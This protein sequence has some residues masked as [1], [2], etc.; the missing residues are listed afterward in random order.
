[1]LVAMGLAL[2]LITY[3][4]IDLQA[5]NDP[6]IDRLARRQSMFTETLSARRGAIL[7]RHGAILAMSL[8]RTTVF[9][10]PALIAEP[11]P[12]ADK[13]AGLL[14]RP[15]AEVLSALTEADS[16]FVPLARDV[17]PAVVAELRALEQPGIGFQ[18]EPKRFTP[19]QQLAGPV[20]GTVGLDGSGASGLERAFEGKL[21]GKA[22][23]LEA[24]QDPT[25]RVIPAAERRE[26]PAVAG[27]D[28]V[29]TLDQ[30]LQYAAERHLVDSVTKTRAKRG[31]AVVA[32]VRT[33]DVL[34]MAQVDGASGST[35]VRPAPAT[36]P[37]RLFTEAF[38]P[39]S[40]NKVITAA[41]VL[42]SGVIDMDTRFSVEPSIKVGAGLY[43]DNEVHG[44]EWWTVRDILERSS[45]VGTIMIAD[46]IGRPSFDRALRNFGYGARTPVN[47]PG[48]SVGILHAPDEIDPS[49][50]GSMPVGYGLA[51]TPMQTLQVYMTLANGGETRP[52]RLVGGTIGADG[53]R[54]GVRQVPSRRIVSE[55]T[56][57]ELRSIL[58]DVVKTGTG[59][60]AAV[61]G[62]TVAGKT[63]T[64]RKPPYLPPLHYMASFAGFLPAD[65]P[66]LAAVVVLDDPEGDIYGGSV[67]AP[68]FS[69]IM[70][71]ALRLRAAS[72]SV[73]AR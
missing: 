57:S 21:H 56:A 4:V 42:E 61:P 22:G 3:K 37:N 40:T 46:L 54:H 67:A 69:A 27:A 25:G 34:A 20:I 73:S 71:D 17:E 30:S 62:T 63:G 70:Q 13:L 16:R 66:E 64:S 72:V 11:G 29:L 10:D 18:E 44:T 7:D 5:V 59:K 19:G 35:P 48:E 24:A 9:A 58:T 65:A 15:K 23:R 6:R 26:Q 47:F 49:I 32:D 8:P 14:G 53:T 2:G 52:L 1:M 41:T 45:N 43:V 28:I 36:D 51:T 55:A 31:M 60:L 12:L 33:G 68:V 50:M 38:E 39:G